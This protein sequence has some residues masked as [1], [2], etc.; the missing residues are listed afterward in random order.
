MPRVILNRVG[1][2]TKLGGGGAQNEEQAQHSTAH[3]MHVH[4]GHTPHCLTVSW[5]S[6][7]TRGHPQ[8]KTSNCKQ[9]SHQ[10]SILRSRRCSN[11][12]A[13][14]GHKASDKQVTN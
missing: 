3:G 8:M 14:P 2:A 13:L 1:R 5:D 10:S 4:T 11:N 7:H 6:E 12:I 9:T